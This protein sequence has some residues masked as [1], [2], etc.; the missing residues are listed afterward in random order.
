M[1][2][3]LL[4]CFSFE[5]H[6]KNSSLFVRVNEFILTYFYLIKKQY[7]ENTYKKLDRKRKNIIWYIHVIKLGKA[8]NA[9]YQAFMTSP[10]GKD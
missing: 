3:K 2:G 5:V 8:L 9:P 1:S 10:S 7:F 4:C 6:V